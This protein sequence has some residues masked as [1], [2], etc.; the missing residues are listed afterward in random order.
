MNDLYYP[1]KLSKLEEYK[2]KL[3]DREK[4]TNSIVD[5][6]IV[7]GSG[8]P[9]YDKNGNLI[10]KKRKFL[11]EEFDG[12]ISDINV[13]SPS[14]QIQN[15]SNNNNSINNNKTNN[16]N[17][18]LYQSFSNRKTNLNINNNQNINSNQNSNNNINNNENNSANNNTFNSRY[19]NKN[20]N[21]NNN[22]LNTVDLNQLNQ[23]NQN[24]N[25]INI[26]RR[27][28]YSNKNNNIPNGSEN[29]NE[30]NNN[31]ANVNLSNKNKKNNLDD[32]IF[33]DDYKGI[34]IIPRKSE[35]TKIK[36]YYREEALKAELKREIEE[37]KLK[38]E[39]EKQLEREKDLKEDLKVQKA[40]EEEKALLKLEKQ[41]KEA[42]EAQISMANMIKSQ[43]NKKKKQLVDLDEYYGKD[44]KFSNRII[45]KDTDN[46]QN[47]DIN[48]GGNNSN[49]NIQGDNYNDN[50][51]SNMI[52][53]INNRMNN[54]IYNNMS[55]RIINNKIN[56][57]QNL[58]KLRE[59]TLNDINNFTVN[60]AKRNE[61]LDKEISQLRN[62]VRSQYLE[63]NDLFKQLKF[64]VEEAE[65]YKDG[66]N[67]ESKII[68]EELLKNRMA[69]VL[70]KN[71]RERNYEDNMNVNYDELINKNINT[72]D[73]NTN[74]EGTSNF[75]YF[76]KENN[77]DN[78]LDNNGN[79]S[80][81]AMAGKNVIE[82]KGE[83][84]LI[85]INNNNTNN[86]DMKDMDIN[87]LDVMNE[88]RK[89]EDENDKKGIMR[90]KQQMEREKLLY[91]DFDQP[92]T[93]DDLYKELNIIES[94]NQTLSPNSK[95]ET[96]KNNF[97]VDY[98]D[99]G[100]KEKP[101]IKSKFIK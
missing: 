77:N 6:F 62:E 1:P 21:N 90:F 54:N 81:L 13:K 58:K 101:K 92:C 31:K 69:N 86:Y 61:N 55:N 45:S 72:I 74:L 10:A 20:I 67:R 53:N 29:Y 46:N 12:V 76:E 28:P 89:N 68:K 7:N 95:I 85:P 39:M 40:I 73:S 65:Q 48:N 75:V 57:V 64:N 56:T 33:D 50:G 24:K 4:Y 91:N 83:N 30:D 87:K 38:K 2:E 3:K 27:T 37:R 59:E 18:R 9:K 36:Q 96:L 99:F 49:E 11:D 19:S 17:P 93:M 35:D 8:A 22:L 51:D 71:L 70:N 26:N 41:K 52:S 78:N 14:M 5:T 23:L 98:G 16:L 44:I 34:G 47:Q 94:I 60:V 97:N 42:I 32:N 88:E 82:L 15:N 84:E 80:S 25:N 79:M 100:N 43:Q 63:M 66:I